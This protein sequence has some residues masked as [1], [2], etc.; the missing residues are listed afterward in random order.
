MPPL[1]GLL[2]YLSCKMGE[3]VWSVSWAEV[4]S[5]SSELE[6]LKLSELN[7]M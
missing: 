2:F 5:G 4:G 6:V 7:K 3:A 1:Q